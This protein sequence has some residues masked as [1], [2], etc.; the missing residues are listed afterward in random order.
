M[1]EIW[2]APEQVLFCISPLTSSASDGSVKGAD[3][4]PKAERD[5]SMK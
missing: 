1:S 3:L 5:A 2:M 4:T